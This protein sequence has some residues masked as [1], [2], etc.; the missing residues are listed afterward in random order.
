MKMDVKP[1]CLACQHLDRNQEDRH[2]CNAF[3][4]GIPEDIWMNRHDHHEPYP[5][6]NGVRFE[7]APIGVGEKQRERAR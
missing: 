4:E 3:E 1:L 2:V 5:G 7:L 6:D